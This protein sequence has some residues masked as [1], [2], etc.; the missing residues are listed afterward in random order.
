MI[1]L[2]FDFPRGE[3]DQTRVSCNYEFLDQVITRSWTKLPKG[4]S[5]F[6]P[7]NTRRPVHSLFL[8]PCGLIQK[9]NWLHNEMVTLT[10]GLTGKV[11]EVFLSMAWKVGEISFFSAMVNLLLVHG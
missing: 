7:W 10:F 3:L 4:V 8:D 1:E 11:G 6:L 5:R 2:C 9:L